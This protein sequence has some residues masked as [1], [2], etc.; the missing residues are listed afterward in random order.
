MKNFKTVL[1]AAVA[2]ACFSCSKDDDPV[3]PPVNPNLLATPVTF[4][5]NNQITIPDNANAVTSEIIIEQEGK[6][7]DASKVTISLALAHGFCRDVVV[8]LVAPD[9]ESTGL[10]KRVNGSNDYIPQNIL[11]FNS[12]FNT[13]L[14]VSGV[15]D[16]PAGDY[17]PTA[18]EN[19][20]PATVVVRDLGEVLNGK[21][22]KGTWK[23]R[24]AD[25]AGGDIGSLRLW[26][27]KF[28][29]GA[30]Q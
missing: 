12:M 26:K 2:A 13:P 16:I 15:G 24:I 21:Q 5:N 3:Y 28:D 7:A 6:I 4:T 17:M 14:N 1:L 11:N 10:I 19:Q 27:L 30:V 23:L 9:G 25:Y 29:A 8:E 22:V 20:N 18:G